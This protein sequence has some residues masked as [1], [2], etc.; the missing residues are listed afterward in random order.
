MTSKV[1]S[2]AD[3]FVWHIDDIEMVRTKGGAGSG[4]HGHT[5]RP[6]KI[7]GSGPGDNT[8]Y[9]AVILAKTA[10]EWFDEQQA[11]S[12]QWSKEAMDRFEREKPHT[13]MTREDF[14]GYLK[15]MGDHRR[16]ILDEGMDIVLN[17]KPGS[18]ADPKEYMQRLMVHDKD[19]YDHN[20]AEA[21]VGTF[22]FDRKVYEGAF[23]AAMNN[24][25]LNNDHHYEHWVHKGKATEMSPMAFWEMM[26]DWRGTAR[27]RGTPYGAY[28]AKFGGKM[29][30]HPRTR[31]A[32]E[33]ELGKLK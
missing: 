2:S 32:V 29:D 31:S 22:K 20:V 5:G 28:Y 16:L 17:R 11:V 6:G 26:A 7:G 15:R 9:G 1:P 14:A 25:H 4:N 27:E 12:E 8:P 19:K 24:H 3:K 33:F 13:E 21:Y 23:T 18:L 30:L 10:Q